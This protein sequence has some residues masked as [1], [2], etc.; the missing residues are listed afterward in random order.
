MISG[1]CHDVDEICALL[2]YYAAWSDN[3]IDVSG[4]PTSPIFKDQEAQ[5]EVH[6]D[7]FR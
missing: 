1:S 5:E 6:L 7:P 4:Q 3:Y 2:G